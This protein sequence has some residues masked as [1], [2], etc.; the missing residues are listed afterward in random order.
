MTLLWKL[1]L[2]HCAHGAFAETQRVVFIGNAFSSYNGG[3][4]RQYKQVAEAC[5]PGLN[6][7]YEHRS[8]VSWTLSQATQDR[9]THALV[10]D[11]QYD[12][13]VIQEQGQLEGMEE[14]LEAVKNVF[15]PAAKTHGAVLGVFE[16]WASPFMV[17][18]TAGTMWLKAYAEKAA[19]LASGTGAEVIIAR[20]GQAFYEILK[21][22]CDYDWQSSYYRALFDDDLLHPSELGHN[23][24]AWNMVLSFNAKRFDGNGCD[25]SKVPNVDGQDEAQKSKFARVACE[26]A[27]ICSKP[28]DAPH[29]SLN[30]LASKLQG[31]W[32]RRKQLPLA[33]GPCTSS[34][35]TYLEKWVVG[36]QWMTQVSKDV[37]FTG[38]SAK[39][40]TRESKHYLRMIG[41][42][43]VKMI[44]EMALVEEI[45]DSKVL[46]TDCT[47]LTRPD[48]AENAEVD[49][50]WCVGTEAWRD[51]DG[52][53]CDW[54]EDYVGKNDYDPSM[55]CLQKMDWGEMATT[56]CPGC[57]KCKARA[58]REL[59]AMHV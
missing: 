5:I 26:L 54:W 52:R 4:W 19:N 10:S 17:N 58:S 24:V 22:T 3:I 8:D 16:T 13:L 51:K 47:V 38:D 14:G 15:G 59:R 20:A 50:C 53:S 2:F 29:A 12:I 32:I 28:Q 55:Y 21:N 49:E 30:G 11:G 39:M 46:F 31:E 36:G 6:V 33:Q 41:N 27:G 9:S 25:A 34:N 48:S 57:G 1:A 42:N 56:I 23:L 35:C 40:I 44:P 45:T 37:N 43:S 7:S 18:L